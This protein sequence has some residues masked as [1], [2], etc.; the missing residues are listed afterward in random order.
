MLKEETVTIHDIAKRAGVSIST[1]SRVL[2]GNTAVRERSR[3][4]VQDAV[5]ELNYQPNIFASGLAGGRS[6]TVG[7]VT[8]HIASPFFDLI[9]RG[10]M[11]EMTESE[12]HPLFAD[13]RWRP[14]KERRSLEMFLDR[15]VDGL[16]ILGGILPEEEL[17]SIRRRVPLILIGRDIVEIDDSCIPLDN[18]GG[19][20]D[21]TKHLIE[22]GHRKIVHLTGILRHDDASQRLAGYRQA[23]I[24]YNLPCDDLVIEGDF[25]EQ[26]G[27]IAVENLLSGGPPFT[28]IFAAND[29]MA[30]GIRLGLFRK[31]IRVPDDVSIIGFDDQP[32]S[33][34]LT[35][36]LTTVGQPALEIGR[37]AAVRLLAKIKEQPE[38]IKDFKAQLIIRDSVTRIN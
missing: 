36:P 22:Y 25:S 4:A 38:I 19:A 27:V 18:F 8:Q 14:E 5:K 15:M 32:A 31:G 17:V 20:Y 28:A 26:S 10:I 12:F 6:K 33:A 37:S 13:G 1:V 35:P 24:D 23:M 21:A 3:L 9:L 16:I 7:V 30:M 11:E 2:N 29:Q 34:F